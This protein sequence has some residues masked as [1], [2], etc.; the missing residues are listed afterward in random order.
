MAADLS[1]IIK[2]VDHASGVFKDI[3][4]QAGG[5]GKTLSGPLK[6][7]G[8]AAA[9]GLGLAVVAGIKFI[10]QAA[11][12]EAGIKRLAA[13]VDASGGS[14]AQQGKA[15]EATIQQRQKLAFSDDDLR[16]SL[17]LLTAITGDSEEALRRQSVAMDFARG[18]NIDL[19]TASKLLGK[20][21]DETVNVLGRYGIRVKEGAD[22]T[23]VLAL[24]QQKFAGQSVAF[25]ESASGKWERF[26]IALD[27]VKETIGAA[28][29]PIVTQLGEKLAMFLEQHQA[30]IE[31]VS[32]AFSAWAQ[33]E[34]FPFLA[35]AFT[36]LT[37]LIRGVMGTGIIQWVAEHKIVLLGLAVALGTL[38]VAFGGP[39]PIIIALVAAGTLLL[40]NWDAIRL[41]IEEVNVW[42]EAH[43]TEMTLAAV[44]VMALIPPYGALIGTLALLNLH[45]EK[46]TWTVRNL[47]IPAFEAV[48]FVVQNVVNPWINANIAVL[49]ALASA[50][51][52]VAVPAVHAFASGINTVA[53]PAVQGIV[54]VIQTLLIPAIGGIAGVAG[55]IG[56]AL[57][58]PFRTAR[59]WVR[60]L[61]EWVHRL[62]AAI[63]SIPSL[64]D[65]PSPGGIF[66][67]VGG[68]LGRQFGGPVAAGMPYIVGEK[69]PEWFM[70]K[71][72]GEIIPS[73]NVMAPQAVGGATRNVTLR[74]EGPLVAITG[75]DLENMSMASYDAFARRVVDA[76]RRELRRG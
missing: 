54:S 32:Q 62:I 15:I 60:V 75:A 55:S 19:G 17:A 56:D 6:L 27:N 65:I 10:K 37:Q 7:G 36:Q 23:D 50:I 22:A 58:G 64:P 5:L 74:V 20:V 76:V 2:G 61:V 68:L 33:S 53:V 51:W 46:A 47:V 34:A 63:N 59:D 1:I 35:A 45:W 21:T 44:G 12:E 24:V 73:V 49:A 67:K 71:V 9:A 14:W 3:D 52:G 43:R 8:A 16:S 66:S 25:A 72:A 69:G 18:A 42:M 30:G 31:R 48:A 57:S 41:K 28:L 70:P 11:D 26:N 13:A 40:A 38:T 4:R 39:I 29:L